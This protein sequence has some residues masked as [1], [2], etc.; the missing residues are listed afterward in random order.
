MV[1]ERVGVMLNKRNTAH[2]NQD[3]IAFAA[4]VFDADGSVNYANTNV[5]NQTVKYI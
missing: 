1:W 3:L 5:T 4:G 2:D